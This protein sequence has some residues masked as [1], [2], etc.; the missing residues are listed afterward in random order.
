MFYFK[1]KSMSGI[2]I[3]M[4]ALG[5]SWSASAASD[6]VGVV[7]TATVVDNTCTPQW[8]PSGVMVEM[9]RV[10]IKDFGADGTGATKPFIISLTDC[11]SDTTKVT[12]TAT[13]TEDIV[14]S[15]L[16]ANVL[17]DGASGVAVGL[18]GG[19]DLSTQFVPNGA[20]SVEYPVVNQS[21][22]MS[23]IAA[24]MRTGANA[25]GAGAV[26]STIGLVVNYE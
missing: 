8:S 13:G 19:A 16:F 26:K 6:S 15:S 7:V 17:A 20:I 11:G 12:V 9:G 10:S 2:A 3:A 5:A 22:D 14:D 25:P 24:L 4:L 18:W 1:K 23:F 21:V